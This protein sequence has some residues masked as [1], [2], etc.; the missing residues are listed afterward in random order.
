MRD[1]QGHDLRETGRL[2]Q[3]YEQAVGLGL[4]S[5]SEAGRLEFVA[6]AERARRRGRR[7]GALFLWLLR[8][9]KT[10]FVTHS[11][12]E[13]AARR[14][15]EHREGSAERPDRAQDADRVF[16]QHKDDTTVRVCLHVARQYRIDDPYHV[17][18]RYKGWTRAQWEEAQHR[19][20][21][22]QWTQL[23][24]PAQD[25]GD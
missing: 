14:L 6:M 10:E 17:A 4:A 23:P 15:R 13:E 11:D 22:R 18:R 12:E 24:V 5:D 1:V 20:K 8:E 7:P 19:F 21:S 2:L 9:R 16:D 25:Y 3:L